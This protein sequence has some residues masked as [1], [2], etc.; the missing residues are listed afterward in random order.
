MRKHSVLSV[1]SSAHAAHFEVVDQIFMA[2]WIFM[3][4][5][6]EQVGSKQK[7]N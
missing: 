7:L 2:L 6:C 5:S 3:T 1:T 4:F